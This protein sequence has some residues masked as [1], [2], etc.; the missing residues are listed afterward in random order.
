VIGWVSGTKRELNDQAE[1]SQEC[2]HCWCVRKHEYNVLPTGT[3][4]KAPKQVET[5]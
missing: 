1:P 3:K 5:H 4:L 2:E